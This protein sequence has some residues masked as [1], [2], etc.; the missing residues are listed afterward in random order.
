MADVMI[1]HQYLFCEK[2]KGNPRQHS[3]IC[4]ERLQC[5]WLSFDD[6]G[7]AKCNFNPMAEKR[8]DQYKDKL[9]KKREEE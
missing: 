2:R 8:V 9:K 5:K 4:Q 1:T 7:I 3:M 6:L